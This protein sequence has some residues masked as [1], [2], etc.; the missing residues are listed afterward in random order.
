MTCLATSYKI[1]CFCS[2]YAT[3][4]IESLFPNPIFIKYKREHSH[5]IFFPNNRIKAGPTIKEH[6][7]AR[8]KSGI[9]RAVSRFVHEENLSK[10][11][12]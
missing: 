10:A 4:K 7:N 2:S 9:V 12:K 3:S 5:L 6:L 11:G 1:C 8:C